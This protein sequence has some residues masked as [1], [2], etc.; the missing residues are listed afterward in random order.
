M[1]IGGGGIDPEGSDDDA[2]IKWL[3]GAF[4]ILY[5]LRFRSERL[6]AALL[7]IDF[8]SCA[9]DSA[10][11][12]YGNGNCHRR[13]G[14]HIDRLRCC[15]RFVRLIVGATGC[16][17][18]VLRN[19]I[20]GSRLRLRCDDRHGNGSVCSVGKGDDLLRFLLYERYRK[21]TVGNAAKL[22]QHILLAGIA[23]LKRCG[24]GRKDIAYIVPGGTL[25]VI[26]KCI[27][28]QI[29]VVSA[30]LNDLLD[31]CEGCVIP[32][33][34]NCGNI[35]GKVVIGFQQCCGVFHVHHRPIQPKHAV[36]DN[37]GQ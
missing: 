8:A 25:C 22:C 3:Y 13:I 9:G 28:R 7:I 29:V 14:C 15:Y 21:H 34:H 17:I 19:A 2:V 24:V 37:A 12:V 33:L 18:T 10:S 5:D 36:C 11:A 27:H 20:D 30:V 32:F 35:C 1:V 6:R 16:G 31:F 4:H 23:L 26:D